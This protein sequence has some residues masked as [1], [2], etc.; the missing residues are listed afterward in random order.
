MAIL[1]AGSTPLITAGFPSAATRCLYLTEDVEVN[2][3]SARPANR[4]DGQQVGFSISPS[5]G[6]AGSMACALCQQFANCAV[7]ARQHRFE[8]RQLDSHQLLI[9]DPTC[10]KQPTQRLNLPWWTFQDQP[11]GWQTRMMKTGASVSQNTRELHARLLWHGCCICLVH[12]WRHC[13]LL[14][15]TWLVCCF[16]QHE[17]A[18]CSAV[19]CYDGMLQGNMSADLRAASRRPPGTS[20]NTRTHDHAR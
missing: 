5:A 13:G 20:V 4:R 12:A 3:W 14:E 7:L 8:P 19:L 6:T 9:A 2:K 17:R 15:L 1:R 18:P 11:W 16:R 10:R